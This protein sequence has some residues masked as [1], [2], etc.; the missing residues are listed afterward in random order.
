MYYLRAVQ[1]KKIELNKDK[2]YA[3]NKIQNYLEKGEK[4]NGITI[5]PNQVYRPDLKYTI[6]EITELIKVRKFYG[7]Y[8]T[9]IH[10]LDKQAKSIVKIK[11]YKRGIFFNRWS[12]KYL[13]KRFDEIKVLPENSNGQNNSGTPN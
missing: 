7:N 11:Y 1:Q 8:I 2:K 5:F 10:I 6:F 13:S 3:E 4:K 9:E 12:R